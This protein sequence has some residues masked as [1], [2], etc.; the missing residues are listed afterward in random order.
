MGVGVN[1][2]VFKWTITQR[3]GQSCWRRRAH[4]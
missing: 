2:G 3:Y 1:F 4:S